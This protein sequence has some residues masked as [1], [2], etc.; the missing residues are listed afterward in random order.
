MSQLIHILASGVRADSGAILDSG[1][2]TT[3]LSGTTTLQTVYQDSDL[4]NPHSNPLTLS[5]GGHVIAYTDQDLKLVIADSTGGS[6]RTITKL[7]YSRGNIISSEIGNDQ[8]KAANINSDVAGSGLG[9]NADGTLEVRVDDSSI[10][11]ASDIL[12]LKSGYD[13]TFGDIQCD[14]ITV[15]TSG[16]VLTFSTYLKSSK[17]FEFTDVAAVNFRSP[18]SNYLT[19]S[20]D[21][22]QLNSSSG[23]RIKAISTD[24]IQILN[25]G[26]A[27]LGNLIVSDNTDTSTSF[28]VLAGAQ[29]GSG[30]TAAVTYVGS[31]FSDFLTT[32]VV[33]VS[34]KNSDLYVR[35]LYLTSESAS[36]FTI[37][38]N[39]TS[40]SYDISWIAYGRYT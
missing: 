4:Q 20:A 5:S 22:L 16:S 2:V 23:S 1:T 11:V 26:G 6:V 37:N 19:T 25:S 21:T 32:P 33:T 28:R 38:W 35:P 36:G 24:G 31:G 9:R 15:G 3:Y 7:Q 17:P 14:Q 39:A 27:G 13:P 18:S 34:A 8:V 40:I 12:R 29:S 30:T 10:E